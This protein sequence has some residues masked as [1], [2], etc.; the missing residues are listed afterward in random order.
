MMM[1]KL[2]AQMMMQEMHAQLAP[3]INECSVGSRIMMSINVQRS[4]NRIGTWE[5]DYKR[6]C[7]FDGQERTEPQQEEI[8]N[9]ISPLSHQSTD[10]YDNDPRIRVVEDS[11]DSIR[12]L[13]TPL[14]EG[15]SP[16]FDSEDVSLASSTSSC[17]FPAVRGSF[18]PISSVSA[19]KSKSLLLGRSEVSLESSSET[20]SIS[21]SSDNRQGQDHVDG[22]Q[23]E[24][25]FSLVPEALYTRADLQG[26][27]IH[28]ISSHS[29]S[30]APSDDN[31]V[32][33]VGT[34]SIEDMLDDCS[35][36]LSSYG[37]L[38]DSEEEFHT[39]TSSLLESLENEILQERERKEAMR[40]RWENLYEHT[41]S[42]VPTA[43]AA[44]PM[45]HHYRTTRNLS[46]ASDAASCSSRSSSNQTFSFQKGLRLVFVGLAVL[47]MLYLQSFYNLS[48]QEATTLVARWHK[49]PAM[50]KR[51][52]NERVRI[53][54]K[55]IL[56][57]HFQKCLNPAFKDGSLPFNPSLPDQ[58]YVLDEIDQQQQNSVPADNAT[59]VVSCID[60]REVKD[61]QTWRD[62]L[63]EIDNG[64]D[65]GLLFWL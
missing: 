33:S 43:S 11:T 62:V 4:L 37:S 45:E 30:S 65:Y 26:R 58:Y 40:R 63:R 27:S 25:L 22:V 31:S 23:E 32:S 15:V 28:R 16:S 9:V 5:N 59:M 41:M 7:H 39:R 34:K 13:T 6:S 2:H 14:V 3:A 50:T 49:K 12:V 8:G 20:V 17:F 24:P 60:S 29:L 42:H 46:L 51:M 35:V 47:S 57:H 18:I 38:Y 52:K 1:Q 21:F 61:R 53:R 10:Y 44:S 64:D 36:S 19:S 48:W 55:E 54:S 56:Q